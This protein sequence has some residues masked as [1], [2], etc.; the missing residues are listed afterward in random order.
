[1]ITSDTTELLN[2]RLHL[3]EQRLEMDSEMKGPTLDLRIN[4]NSSPYGK[5]TLECR[6]PHVLIVL[7]KEDKGC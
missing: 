2:C 1:M 4:K 7:L 6:T 3:S 5:R